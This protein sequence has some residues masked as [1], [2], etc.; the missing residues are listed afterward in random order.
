MPT[1]PHIHLASFKSLRYQ[2]LVAVNMM[3][4]DYEV[5]QAE[6]NGHGQLV[7]DL[8]AVAATEN[9]TSVQHG[10]VRANLS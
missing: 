6:P 7:P 5:G 2:F 8:N 3:P 1:E 10:T 9:T 4:H